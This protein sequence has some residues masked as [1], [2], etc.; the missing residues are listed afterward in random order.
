MR[1]CNINKINYNFRKG[2][3]PKL[4]TQWNIRE[5]KYRS[6]ILTDEMELYVL[7]LP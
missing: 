6:T 5:K 7:K 4:H 3:I 2:K 1:K